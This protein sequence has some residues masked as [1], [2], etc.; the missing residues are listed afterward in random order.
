MNEQTFERELGWDDEVT[1][2]STYTPLKEGDYRFRMTALERGRHNGSE[3]LPACAKAIVTLEIL[4]DDGKKIGELKHNL[5]LHTKTEGLL[6]AFFLATGAKK[7][8][9]SLNIKKGFND[10]VG[11]IGWCHIVI[12]KW[13]GNDG[14]ERENNKITKFLEPDS[15]KKTQAPAAAAP[16]SSGGFAWG[17]K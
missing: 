15:V 16:A 10:S 5:F 3:K 6:S 12:D 4:D 9:E 11:R 14:S 2:E 1:N 17:K 7:H 8:G 13:K